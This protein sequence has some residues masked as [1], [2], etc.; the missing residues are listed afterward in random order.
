ME[1]LYPVRESAKALGGV[2]EWTVRAWLSQGLLRRTKVGR[3][4]MIAE[5]E[6]ERFVKQGETPLAKP[7]T[8]VGVSEEASERKPARNPRDAA[9]SKK[10]KR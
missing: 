2:S 4:T 5:S 1:K 9:D 6:L 3:R 8:E 7:T 10:G